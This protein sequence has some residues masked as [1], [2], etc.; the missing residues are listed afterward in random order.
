MAVFKLEITTEDREELKMY[1]DSPLTASKWESVWE[2]LFR[3]RHKHGYADN[4]INQLLE[5]DECNELMERLEQIY[6]DIS[7]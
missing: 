3:P 6:K 5:S 2:Y 1:S 4:R 7:H